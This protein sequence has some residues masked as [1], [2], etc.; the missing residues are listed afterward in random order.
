MNR[1]SLCL[2]AYRLYSKDFWGKYQLSP[3]TI[4]GFQEIVPD[5]EKDYYLN[6]AKT[7]IR[8]K[9]IKHIKQKYERI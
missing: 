4:W 9:K 8:I 3:M 5:K 2:E 1:E 6:K 7:L